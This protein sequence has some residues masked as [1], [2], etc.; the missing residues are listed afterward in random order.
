[1]GVSLLLLQL[2]ELLLGCTLQSIYVGAEE[3]AEDA[4]EE[5][6]WRRRPLLQQ[7]H[8]SQQQQGIRCVQRVQARPSIQPGR[9]ALRV[10][11]PFA[12]LWRVTPL[13]LLCLPPPPTQ[14]VTTWC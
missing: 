3:A 10:L 14:V 4:D 7:Q 8:H 1:V 12:P 2:L 13:L 11:P 5:A 6:T 9:E